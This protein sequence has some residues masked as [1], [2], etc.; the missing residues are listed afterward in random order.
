MMQS[1]PR[2]FPN[3]LVSPWPPLPAVSQLVQASLFVLFL[4]Y[5]EGGKQ[6]ELSGQ[7]RLPGQQPW[8]SW[9]RENIKNISHKE[10]R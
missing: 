9:R 10:T 7:R 1:S 4:S 3:G 5:R 8:Q 6:Q 2:K